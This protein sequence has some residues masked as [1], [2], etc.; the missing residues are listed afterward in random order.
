M[1]L[2]ATVRSKHGDDFIRTVDVLTAKDFDKVGTAAASWAR[3]RSKSV[4]LYGPPVRRELSLQLE[5]VTTDQHAAE[6]ANGHKAS[7][8]RPKKRRK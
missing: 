8:A 5:W 3:S 4:Q 6:P 1:F 2:R 7:P